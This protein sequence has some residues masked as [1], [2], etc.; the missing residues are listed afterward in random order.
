VLEESLSLAEAAG[1]LTSLVHALNDTGFLYEIGGEFARS[2]EHRRRALEVAER[3]GDPAAVANM[4]FRC[5]QNAFLAGD[6]TL[7]RQY[8]E[9]SSA[10]A[11]SA[12]ASSILA[13]PLFGL[14]LLALADGDRQA[15]TR[16]AQ[17]CLTLGAQVADRKVLQGG[18]ILLAEHELREGRPGEALRRLEALDGDAEGLDLH[19]ALPAL[20]EACLMAGDL[21]KAQ[22]CIEDGLQQAALAHNRVVRVDLLRVKALL[23]IERGQ[24]EDAAAV[25]DEA[26]GLARAMPYPFAVARLL[27]ADGIVRLR[28]GD[29][30]AAQRSLDE[31]LG[32]FQ[33]LGA[34]WH[35]IQVEADRRSARQRVLP[36]R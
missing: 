30:E 16:Y 12:G 28:R 14:G 10:V 22:R 32:L 15:V 6:W 27:Q 19:S 20:A 9:R 11:R 34:A 5:G 3:V 13:Y 7:A 25:L 4:S 17:E 24:G 23:L 35:A 18:T 26:L 31:A 33:S 1:D 21:T 29:W 2:G 8:F 36:R